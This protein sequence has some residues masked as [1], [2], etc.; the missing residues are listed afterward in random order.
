[1]AICSAFVTSAQ[2][3]RLADV[4][5]N[6]KSGDLCPHLP[7]RGCSTKISTACRLGATY[8]V[9]GGFYNVLE[10]LLRGL[11]PV[12]PWPGGKLPW[13]AEHAKSLLALQDFQG[14]HDTF[15]PRVSKQNCSVPIACSTVASLSASMSLP[16][17]MH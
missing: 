13:R 17:S 9:S 1:M 7:S 3:S 10:E 2:D 12:L 16:E 6:A 14:R 15:K 4:M 11:L 8:L 5:P